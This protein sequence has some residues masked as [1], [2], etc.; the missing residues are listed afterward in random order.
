MFD[1][2]FIDGTTRSEHPNKNH[3][4]YKGSNDINYFRPTVK[5]FKSWIDNH[6]PKEKIVDI[7]ILQQYI[8]EVLKG[9]FCVNFPDED[10][11][12]CFYTNITYIAYRHNSAFD[13]IDSKFKSKKVLNQLWIDQSVIKVGAT[14]DF[15]RFISKMKGYISNTSNGDF[16]C[17]GFGILPGSGLNHYKVEQLLHFQL[18]EDWESGEWFKRQIRSRLISILQN[19][20]LIII[21]K[22]VYR[23]QTKKPTYTLQ[24]EE[25]APD[26]LYLMKPNLDDDVIKELET[27]FNYYESLDDNDNNVRILNYINCIKFEC[28]IGSTSDWDRRKVKYLWGR[29]TSNGWVYWKLAPIENAHVIEDRFGTGIMQMGLLMD[30]DRGEN[31][32]FNYRWETKEWFLI[33]KDEMGSLL[34]KCK[35][36]L[37]LDGTIEGPLL[38]TRCKM[39]AAV[40]MRAADVRMYIERGYFKV[41]YL[42]RLIRGN[43]Y[44]LTNY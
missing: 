34:T 21:F 16:Y 14:N 17:I 31:D 35:E 39:V 2:N 23:T 22:G 28:K 41:A 13:S 37:Q 20:G 10:V 33:A 12:E 26:T 44:K 4:R 5:D 7:L 15:Y 19:L 6:P 24:N 32:D 9:M 3:R 43:R 38:V 18:I 25:L 11:P 27:I 42:D 1:D 29:S 40:K 36:Q 8:Q 30:G